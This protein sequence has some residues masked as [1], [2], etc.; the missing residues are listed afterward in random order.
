MPTNARGGG[1]R[2]PVS[3]GVRRTPDPESLDVA[4]VGEVLKECLSRRQIM[5][6]LRTTDTCL[7]RWQGEGCLGKDGRMHVMPSVK[8]GHRYYTHR[9]D[10]ASFVAAINAPAE[11]PG[12]RDKGRA[13][14]RP[15]ER[16]P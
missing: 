13:A 6:A 2:P 8:I 4:N 11:K 3:G 12:A 15:V 7:H 1:R 5:D 16:Q 14:G 9:D 10:L